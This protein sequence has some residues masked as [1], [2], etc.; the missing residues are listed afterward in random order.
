MGQKRSKELHGHGTMCQFNRTGRLVS[1]LHTLSTDNSRDF[2][3]VDFYRLTDAK[4]TLVI[5]NNGSGA[6]RVNVVPF[7]GLNRG[8]EHLMLY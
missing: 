4:S 1:N 6:A 2:F 7:L 3:S 8:V 5:A